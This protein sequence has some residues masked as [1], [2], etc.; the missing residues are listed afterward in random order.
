MQVAE[1]IV[2]LINNGSVDDAIKALRLIEARI[3]S[4]NSR[5]VLM[6]A[7]YERFKQR[8]SQKDN[9][10]E[11]IEANTVELRKRLIEIVEKFAQTGEL[12]NQ[13]DLKSTKHVLLL[14][15]GI[16]TRA[17]W[18]EIVEGI[19]ATETICEVVPIRYGHF[20]LVK[21]L[22]PLPFARAMPIRKIRRELQNAKAKYQHAKISAIAHSFGTYALMHAIRNDADLELFRVILC[23][24]VVPEQWEFEN[25]FI[26]RGEAINIVNDCGVRDVWPVLARCCTWGYGASGTFGKAGVGVRDRKFPLSHSEFFNPRFI[27]KYW[28]PFIQSGEIVRPKTDGASMRSPALINMLSS[29]LIGSVMRVSLWAIII[30]LLVF[31][32]YIFAKWVPIFLSYLWTSNKIG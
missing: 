3:A 1:E 32:V 20:D 9:S 24:S 28:V 25:Y 26:T 5:S 19:F 16:R 15:H 8:S 6:S 23:G 10:P 29:P 12:S 14:L 22:F 21:F 30:S 31:S 4:D 7:I 17:D 2:E 11:Q 13:E 18:F 27:S